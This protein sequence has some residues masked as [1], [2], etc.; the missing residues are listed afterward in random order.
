MHIEIYTKPD[1]PY[2]TNAKQL[3]RDRQIPFTEQ[4]LNEDFTREILL[5]RFPDAKT[6]PVVIIDGY[7]IGGYTELKK[8]LNEETIST[9]KLLNEGF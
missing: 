7:R 6:F 9:A 2:C 1:C 8:Q 5:E 4:K 3:L